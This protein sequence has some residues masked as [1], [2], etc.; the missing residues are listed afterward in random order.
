MALI[1]VH[2]SLHRFAGTSD[3]AGFRQIK[4]SA[5]FA[6]VLREDMNASF[7]SLLAGGCKDPRWLVAQ[8]RSRKQLD[9][10]RMKMRN[11]RRVSH[12]PA[13]GYAKSRS[14]PARWSNMVSQSCSA[15]A[16]VSK[17]DPAHPD[18]PVDMDGPPRSC[19]ARLPVKLST[20]ATLVTDHER[21]AALA[22]APDL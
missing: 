22:R 19:K 16:T 21:E 13:Q 7:R 8:M 18:G 9:R 12:R 10:F 6:R 3:N 20:T 5:S 2:R 4:S 14:Y 15:S 1:I 17:G 11:K